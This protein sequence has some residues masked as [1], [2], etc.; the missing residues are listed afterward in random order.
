MSA[1]GMRLGAALA[2][3]CA[4]GASGPARA[5]DIVATGP[6]GAPLPDVAVWLVPSAGGKG[7]AGAAKPAQIGQRDRMFEALVTTVEA[8]RSVAFPNHDVVR[9]HVYSFSKAKAFDIKL[10]AG[11]EAPKID[12]AQPGLV[13]LGCN[14]HDK[15]IAYLRVVPSGVHAVTDAKGMARLDAPAGSWTVMA[16]HPALGEQSEGVAFPAGAGAGVVKVELAG[17]K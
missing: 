12:F 9:H 8:G 14:I 3:A 11:G 4:L 13:V 10:Y 15:M 2:L 5:A 7:P 16:W 17:G 6:G 1:S